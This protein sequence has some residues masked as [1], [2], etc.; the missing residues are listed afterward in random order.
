MEGMTFREAIQRLV[1]AELVLVSF[2]RSIED[3]N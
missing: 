3:I 2:T 1:S